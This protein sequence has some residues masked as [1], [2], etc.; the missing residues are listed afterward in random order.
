MSQEFDLLRMNVPIGLMLVSETDVRPN[1]R[2]V[3][4]QASVTAANDIL[5]VRSPIVETALG[6]NMLEEIHERLYLC[7]DVCV[8]RPASVGA[9]MVGWPPG[10]ALC[11]LGGLEKPN[12]ILPVTTVRYVALSQVQSDRS[13]D[14][15]GEL[16]GHE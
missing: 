1:L 14:R 7:R 2:K 13:S 11:C 12:I 10:L 16:H 8:I 4:N 5:V 6:R 3:R 15:S 9:R